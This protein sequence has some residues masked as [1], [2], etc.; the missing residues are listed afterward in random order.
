MGVR[1]TTLPFELHPGLPAGGVP[2]RSSYSAAAAEALALGWAFAP[3]ARVPNT[4]RV[5]ELSEWV[6]REH[7]GA[8][9]RFS[10]GVFRAY[11]AA[12]LAIDSVGVLDSLLAGVGVS[13]GEAWDAVAG[14][15]PSAWVDASMA[16]ARSFGV[17]GT[18]AWLLGDDPETGLLV[19]GLQPRPFFE[20]VVTNMRSKS[21]QN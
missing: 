10:E 14:G 20:R 6:R 21:R 2:R 16:M 5:L 18:P 11:W 19:P 17:A 12:G 3:P 7:P 13:V 4:R 15:A 9:G 1:V 8:F